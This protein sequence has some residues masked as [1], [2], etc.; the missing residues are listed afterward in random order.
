SERAFVFF[1]IICLALILCCAY[2]LIRKLFGKKRHGEKKQKGLKGFFGDKGVDLITINK[3]KVN[4]IDSNKGL[5][6]RVY[7]N[8]Y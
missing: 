2:L 7:T 4:P 3:N 5:S 1:G 8:I 6:F